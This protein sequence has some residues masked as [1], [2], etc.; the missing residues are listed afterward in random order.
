[1]SIDHPDL[2]ALVAALDG[3]LEEFDGEDHAFYSQ[4]NGL[5]K[6]MV[7]LVAYNDATPVGCGGLKAFD[8]GSAEIKR[9]YVPPAHRREQI[10]ARL[11][12]ALEQHA[13]QLGYSRCILETGVRQT[14]A[15]GLYERNGYTRINNYAQ[16]EGVQDSVCYEKAL[17]N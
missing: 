15:V 6:L 9:M 8:D 4:F 14:A 7:A 16:Y 11:L 10:A 3:E 5:D 1:M 2:L 12:A 13:Q 17:G